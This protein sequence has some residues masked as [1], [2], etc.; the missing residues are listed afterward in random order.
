MFVRLTPSSMFKGCSSRFK[1]LLRSHGCL[2][3]MWKDTR[4]LPPGSLY[5][6]HVDVGF[7][8]LGGEDGNIVWELPLA[9]LRSR[10]ER[11]VKPSA[12]YANCKRL[13]GG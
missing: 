11:N 2:V 3:T 5:G 4:L 13:C 10:L 6:I 12:I 1:C 8:V 9:G 7:A